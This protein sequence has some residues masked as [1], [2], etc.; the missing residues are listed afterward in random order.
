NS[1]GRALADY[2]LFWS[3][4][5]IANWFPN[6]TLGPTFL[7]WVSDRAQSDGW[8][9]TRRHIEPAAL[10]LVLLGVCLFVAVPIQQLVGSSLGPTML[11][12]PLPL[13]VWAAVRFGEKGASGAVLIVAVVFTWGSL[14]GPGLFP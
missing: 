12:L 8:N 14:H 7:I 10:I 5:I 11:L 13:L 9:P 3:Q 1:G 2:W 4:W 6:L